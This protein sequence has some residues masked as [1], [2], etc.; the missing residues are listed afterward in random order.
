MYLMFEPGLSYGTKRLT[1][2]GNNIFIKNNTHKV[3]AAIRSALEKLNPALHLVKF[4]VLVSNETSVPKASI[5]VPTT[6]EKF[7]IGFAV[8]PTLVHIPA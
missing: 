3:S 5:L 6:P 8:K 7:T 1:G 4:P 2:L